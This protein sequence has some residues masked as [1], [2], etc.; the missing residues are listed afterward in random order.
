M[1][2]GQGK[3]ESTLGNGRRALPDELPVGYKRT[4]VG[5]IPKD[6]NTHPLRDDISLFSGHHVLARDY[7]FGGDGI[8]YVT[9]PADFP[10]GQIKQTKFTTKPTTI[11]RAGDILVTVKGSG[12][13]ALVK[14]DGKYCISRQLMAIRPTGWDPTF[15]QYS[16]LQNA[17]R[18]QAASTGLI[19]GLS[20]SD[21]LDWIRRFPCQK[22]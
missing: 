8:P 3:M 9:G 12:S 11:C 20:R 6:W 5:V 14:A 13:G 22:T 10:D 1:E 17:S 15:L 4:E 18:I 21:I 16:L 7:N 2:G 19:P